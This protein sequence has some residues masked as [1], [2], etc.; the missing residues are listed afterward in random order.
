VRETHI[1]FAYFSCKGGLIRIKEEILVLSAKALF[2]V[3]SRRKS[4]EGAFLKHLL[5]DWRLF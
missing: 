5:T 2:R 1:A 3:K 4:D